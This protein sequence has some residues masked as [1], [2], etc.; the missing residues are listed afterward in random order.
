M[1][2]KEPDVSTVANL[3]NINP[4]AVHFLWMSIG[5]WAKDFPAPVIQGIAKL[6]ALELAGEVTG[7]RYGPDDFRKAFQDLDRIRT[8]LRAARKRHQNGAVR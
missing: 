6:E 4:F 3:E 2:M 7:E 5:L 1:T 8:A